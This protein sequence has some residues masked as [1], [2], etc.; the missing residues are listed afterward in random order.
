MEIAIVP[1]SASVDEND[2]RGGCWRGHE[3]ERGVAKNNSGEHESEQ[4]NESD[5]MAAKD[6]EHAQIGAQGME[7]AW[8]RAQ[9]RC[10]LRR[11]RCE[12]ASCEMCERYLVLVNLACSLGSWQEMRCG[13]LSF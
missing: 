13:P 2:L 11:A 6:E 7:R 10:K 3:R 8:Q 9:T 12:A 1:L 5:I 4:Q